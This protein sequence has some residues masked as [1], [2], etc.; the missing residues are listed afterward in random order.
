MQK[1]IFVYKLSD[2]FS[3]FADSCGTG[4]H[5]GAGGAGIWKRDNSPSGILQES[6][7]LVI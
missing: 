7:I 4:K 1:R 5:N 6:W 2:D 3:G